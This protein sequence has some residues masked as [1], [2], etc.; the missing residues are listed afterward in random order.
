MQKWSPNQT[1]LYAGSWTYHFKRNLR[2]HW[3]L[4]LRDKSYNIEHI[5]TAIFMGL[6]MVSETYISCQIKFQLSSFCS[7]QQTRASLPSSKCTSTYN[8][9]M[10]RCCTCLCLI[11]FAS[12]V[13]V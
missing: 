2:K 4:F 9:G 10:Q 13:K 1:R 11:L 8:G 6:V 7:K 5:A 3:M 12:S